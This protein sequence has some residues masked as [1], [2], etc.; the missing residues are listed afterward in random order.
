MQKIT[1][2]HND[3]VKQWKKL[4]TTKGRKQ[5]KAYLIESWHLV[6]EALKSPYVQYC[7]MNQ[8]MYEQYGAVIQVPIYMIS[9]DIVKLLAQTQTPQAIF[10]VVSMNEPTLDL[11][12]GK[13]MLIDA[14]QDPGN[15]GTI[16][17]TADAAGFSAVLVGSG[18]VDIYNDKTIRAMQGSQFH[19]VVCKVDLLDTIQHFKANRIKV[20]GTSLHERSQSLFDIEPIQNCAVIVGNEGSGVQQALLEASDQP[21]FI[22]M[23]GKAESLNVAVAASL[24]MY[25]FMKK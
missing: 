19:I 3:Y 22:P 9:E 25:H 16:I 11:S 18:S 4:L 23:Q 21:I 5:A 12:H 1:S 2:V 24:I 10:A 20:Y 8:A 7:M 14:V 15:L 17:R 13:Y 6:E